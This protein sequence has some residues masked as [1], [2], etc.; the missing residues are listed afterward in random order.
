MPGCT[1]GH[2]TRPIRSRITAGAIAALLATVAIG[3]CSGSSQADGGSTTPADVPERPALPAAPAFP[4]QRPT[5]Q[6][7]PLPMDRSKPEKVRIPALGVSSALMELGLLDDGTLEVPP[8][9]FPAGW[10][11]GAPTPGEI[12][13]AIITGHVR[14]NA[15]EGVFAGLETLGPD[16]RIIV[17]R[18]DGT[19][20]VFEVS[21]VVEYE[22]SRFRT[23]AVYGNIDHAGLRLI[24]CGGLNR[25]TGDFEDNIVVFAVLAES[26]TT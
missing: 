23:R 22:K 24:T 13:P 8:G 10:Y 5:T 11:T 25:L 26:R 18:R 3:G 20:A 16:D 14:W 12:G 7:P 17:A 9:P 6:A 15:V 1:D 2:R 4:P 21:K 19:K